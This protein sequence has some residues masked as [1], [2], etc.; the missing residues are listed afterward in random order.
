MDKIKP[1]KCYCETINQTVFQSRDSNQPSVAAD[2]RCK[3]T[4]S[5]QKPI[6]PKDMIWWRYARKVYK[7]MKNWVAVTTHVLFRLVLLAGVTG[8]NIPKDTTQ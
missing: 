1:H 6:L 3:V 8:E 5:A 2:K 7:M 4:R